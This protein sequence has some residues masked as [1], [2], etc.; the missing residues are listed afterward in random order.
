MRKFTLLFALLLSAIG[1]TAWA[2]TVI[3]VTETGTNTL[4]AATIMDKATQGDLYV[5]IMNHTTT[6]DK[7]ITSNGTMAGTFDAQNGA[8]TWKVVPYGL[9][10]FALQNYA[11][12]KYFGGTSRPAVMVDNIED[13][14]LY[15]PHDTE[16]GVGNINPSYN[17]DQ[18]VRWK[19]YPGNSPW[20]NTNGANESTTVQWNT[21]TGN[22]TCLFTYEVTLS[23]AYDVTYKVEDINGNVL[24]TSAPVA[25]PDGTQITTLPAEYQKTAF[26]EYSTIDQT[27]S[28][29]N[30]EFTFVATEK[31]NPYMHYS[32]D[33]ANATWYNF[34]IRGFY[35]THNVSGVNEIAL[36][37]NSEPFADKSSW[38]LIGNPYEGFSVVN[39][40]KGEGYYLVWTTVVD[41]PNKTA[42]YGDDAKN[43][44]FK[45][46]AEDA[47]AANKKWMLEQN[48]CSDRPGGFVLRMKDNTN[49]YFHHNNDA[50]D[51][52]KFL[53]TCSV[54]EWGSV[55]NDNGSTI[56]PTT[57][58]EALIALFNKLSN[59]TFGNGVNQYGTDGTITTDDATATVISVGGV[60]MN[61]ISTAY[62]D[63]YNALK[64]V[65]EKVS[66]N[67]PT[68]GFYRI[69]GATSNK[70]LA[71]GLAT[72]NKFNMTTD[73]DASTI[74]YF[75]GAKLVNY[76]TGLCNGMS[77]SAWSWTTEA[78]ASTVAFEDGNTNGGY[79]IK[80]TSAYFYDNGDNTSSADRGQS[81]NM[82]S[83]N[84]RYR[85]WFLEPVSSLPI[86]LTA[87]ADANY[88]T[89]YMPVPV[90]V[91]GAEVFTAQLVGEDLRAVALAGAIPANTGVILKGATTEATAN[92]VNAADAVETAL[93]GSVGAIAPVAG[94]YVFSIVGD[95][96]GFYNFG[97]DE[98]KGFKA[99][100]VSASPVQG[101]KLDFG[102]ATAIKQAETTKAGQAIYDLSGRRVEK[103]VKGV[104]IVGGKKVIK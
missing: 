10:A 7:Y 47:E 74:F 49:I 82:T 102:S 77:A 34:M 56:V 55:H 93:T 87:V 9:D 32:A 71:A 14:T 66:L 18:S 88:S 89:L 73:V 50:G 42:T 36:S 99:Y 48:N 79:G 52:G 23:V 103:A 76:G 26:Y 27:V 38:A 37:A 62:P 8:T 65:S 104:Y 2:Q 101:F 72:N 69:K 60:I 16:A 90:E 20:I 21:G 81:V 63:A 51:A 1:T 61:N 13:A 30:T 91:S 58:E 86:S 100:Y 5:S 45:S 40:E 31:A 75:D 19:V 96:L 59:M 39:K 29:T 80:S 3:H 53:R 57:D 85:K 35:M 92:I 12:G 11:T 25:T 15:T 95:K 78:N 17:S 97:G 33:F 68:A 94:S 67:M 84:V 98:L 4:D 24:F 28:S 46:I 54:N 70:Y 6:S 83:D 64:T 22:W 44:Q 43:I 41:G